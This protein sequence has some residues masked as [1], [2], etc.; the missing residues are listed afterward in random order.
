MTEFLGMHWTLALTI[1]SIVLMIVDLFIF[2]GGGLTFL[3]DVFF[4]FIILHFIPTDNWIWLTLWSVII[5]LIVL[6]LH[7]FI[8]IKFVKQFIDKFIAP[9]K[10]KSLNNDLIGKTGK[11]CWIEERT[12]ILVN[13]EH[14]PCILKNG[15]Q[16]SD[17]ANKKAKIVSWNDSG[18]L[19]VSIID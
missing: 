6:A 19:T 17:S 2:Q 9:Q 1:I 10:H 18:E 5:F 3:A 4:T 15:L 14:I 11:I 16:T 8:Y 12:Y 13:D 7:L